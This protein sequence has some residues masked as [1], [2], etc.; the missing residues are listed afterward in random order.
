M[1]M[2]DYTQVYNLQKQS[3][4]P[5]QG[6]PNQPVM[7][8]QG[9]PNQPI[10]PMQ[11]MPNQ[12]LGVQMD[13]S[14]F[15]ELKNAAMGHA[16]DAI[17]GMKDKMSGFNVSD[18]AG[19]VIARTGDMI[20][21]AKEKAERANI[22]GK[23]HDIV[24]F[25]SGVF[26]AL[27]EKLRKLFQ[28]KEQPEEFNL[29]PSLENTETVP[30]TNRAQIVLIAVIALVLGG[31]GITVGLLIAK[32]SRQTEQQASVPTAVSG[33]AEQALTTNTQLAKIE[34]VSQA[35]TETLR[36]FMRSGNFTAASMDYEGSKYDL[37]DINSDGIPEL[38]VSRFDLDG[39]DLYTFAN[40]KVMQL[41]ENS[42]ESGT[43]LYLPS[44]QTVLDNYS[45]FGYID[46][47]IYSFTATEFRLSHRLKCAF[48]DN[49]GDEAPYFM[50]DDIY[51]KEAGFMT[52]YD[53]FLSGAKNVGRQYSFPASPE[54]LSLTIAVK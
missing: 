53:Q 23:L 51:V 36:N 16:G 26:E 49:A 14:G 20:S 28:R 34:V 5:P 44:Q 10:I 50:I 32:G 35:Y 21:L 4:V 6:I 37:A 48:Q 9:V 33:T 47:S 15:G 39:C 25:I 46:L 22:K 42:G 45:Q 29:N 31:G 8:M 17:S 3:A 12:Q 54:Q 43:L 41:L 40:G 13:L 7:P 18:V 24:F 2:T 27:T 38:I 30:Q 1:F 52:N 19:T 11:E